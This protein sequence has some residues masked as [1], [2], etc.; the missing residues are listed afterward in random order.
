[1]SLNDR[2]P[3]GIRRL[4]AGA[5]ALAALVLAAPAAAQNGSISG[6]VLDASGAPIAGAVIEANRDASSVRRGTTT[7]AQGAYRIAG[8]PAGRYQVRVRRAGFQSTGG[9]I[10]L[11]PGE[12]LV[13]D[14]V[15]QTRPLIMDTIT[16][17]A[18]SQT[19]ISRE[20]TEFSTTINETALE[21]LPTAHDPAEIVTYTPGARPGQVWGGATAQANSYQID[22]LATNHPGVGGDLL[23]P[24]MSW[25]ES[26]EIRGLGAAA[27]YGNFQ[28]GLINI[29]TK[30][31][32]NDFEAVLHGSTETAMLTGSN[33][34][35]YDLGAELRSRYDLEAELRGPIVKNRLFYYLAGQTIRR[36]EQVVNHQR[37]ATSF[38][39]PDLIEWDEQ[40]AFGKLLWQPTNRDQLFASGGYIGAVAQRHGATGY[41]TD[42][43]LRMEAPSTFYNLEYT[44]LFAPG[45]ELELAVGGF[46]RDETREPADVGVPGIVVFGDEPRPTYQN[47]AFRHRL[48]PQ[49]LTVTAALGVEA[50]VL[51]M[52]HALKVGGEYV[53]GSWTDQRLRNGGMTWRPAALRND[54]NFSGD[55]PATWTRFVDFVPS[56]WGGEVDLVADV[57]NAALYLQDNIEVSS[58]F[59]ISPGVRLG[60]WEGYITP[61]GGIG[62]RFRAVNDVAAEGRL[63]VT[64]DVTGRNDLVVKAHVGRYHQNMFAQFYDRVQGGNVFSNLQR[65]YYR[66][67]LEDPS[68]T[69][70][71]AERD[72]LAR[73]GLMQ[74]VQETRLNQSGPVE[75]YQQPYVDQL[76]VGVEK[77][78]GRWLKAEAVYVHRRNGNMVSLVD[79]NAESNYTRFDDVR[80]WSESG[81][82]LIYNGAQLFLSGAYV[83]NYAVVDLLKFIAGTTVNPPPIPP[84]LTLADTLTLTWD[85]DYVLTTVPEARRT[86]DQ[87]Q[88]VMR[89]GFPRFGGTVSL[90]HSRLEGNLDNVS[91]YEDPSGFGAGPFVN[92]NQAVN[93]EGRLGNTSPWELKVSV[94]GEVGAGFRG[95]LFW[96]EALG[97]R[98]TP[99]FTLRGA[100]NYYLNTA[101]DTIHN[102]LFYSVYGQPVFV[103]RRG[104][105]QYRNRSTM[106]LHLERGVRFGPGEWLF[107]LDAFNVFA[108]DTPL[109]VN[110]AVNQ[111]KN[112][113]P[114]LNLGVDPTQYFGAV[115]ERQRP[116]SIRLGAI[117]RF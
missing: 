60:W 68:R 72:Q 116:R 32:T 15:M 99:H 30:S 88:L 66:G 112:Y 9:G 4:L 97:D 7:D 101:G 43:A 79:R 41:E 63:G 34:Q 50:Q 83:P 5:L 58:R 114:F 26:V 98:Y 27:E 59:S 110:T 38:Y 103:G 82:P 25:I 115:Q 61:A 6:R 64:F 77:Q 69:F 8:L 111:G 52:T 78:L 107:S 21:L 76:V 87:L 100:E 42:A 1:M 109:R 67:D 36:D 14:Y 53:G 10:L 35:Q 84:G 75:N 113:T 12:T 23:K 65:W 49:S 95:G 86:F 104:Q 55:D 96:N 93:F 31:G 51:G 90:V 2:T 45:S 18:G 57:R 94:Y 39:H 19:V 47:P 81:E 28:G 13:Q 29:T 105:L 54:R 85:P 24:S 16:A 89:M 40:K 48:A 17:I 71:G 3:A 106:D 37:G 91:G 11:A 44:H 46:D 56:E 73:Q 92:P 20:N 74:L 102:A 22:G 117:V 62:P 33:L 70:T 80:I 108:R